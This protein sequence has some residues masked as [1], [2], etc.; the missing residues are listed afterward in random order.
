MEN[1]NEYFLLNNLMTIIF[2]IK[3]PK[4]S[5]INLLKNRTI[6]NDK[7]K[8]EERKIILINYII[9]KYPPLNANEIIE[10]KLIFV[11]PIKS[12]EKYGIKKNAHSLA[13]FHELMNISIN[14]NY[15]SYN[16]KTNKFILNMIKSRIKKIKEIGGSTFCSL[17]FNKELN[18]MI[19]VS[20]GN[21]LYSILREN[22][23]REYEIIYISTE[24]DHDI[25]IPYQISS[26]NNDYNNMIIQYHNININDIIIISNKKEIILEYNNYINLNKDINNKKNDEKLR[27]VYLYKY[28]I[29]NKTKG[30]E[31]NNDNMSSFSTS[32]E[33]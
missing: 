23:S 18:K 15:F 32:L 3:T 30:S 27:N 13:L 28:K 6:Y 17:F 5:L 24:Q 19:S 4:T 8:T 22:K 20:V 7:P 16:D 31:I 2:L 25:N 26:L 29:I 11:E 14:N 1:K 33:S 9:N 21:I 12:W 10:N